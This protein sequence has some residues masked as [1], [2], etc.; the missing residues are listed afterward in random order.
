MAEAPPLH[1][2]CAG[3][4]IRPAIWVL[5]TTRACWPKRWLVL[6]ETESHSQLWRVLLIGLARVAAAAL[7]LATMAS[8]SAQDVEPASNDARLEALERRLAELEA[9]LHER[10]AQDDVEDAPGREDP[11]DLSHD[12]Y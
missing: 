11:G 12:E 1:V 6:I 7:V 4:L 9:E 8:A 5:A 3:L 2:S 10:D